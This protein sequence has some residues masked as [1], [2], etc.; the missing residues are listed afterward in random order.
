MVGT[1]DFRLGD[2]DKN[3]PPGKYV[4]Y[5][6]F[7]RALDFW[8]A[9]EKEVAERLSDFEAQGDVSNSVYLVLKGLDVFSLK[10]GPEARESDAVAE[11][12]DRHRG[13]AQARLIRFAVDQ[14]E[15]TG[16]LPKQSNARETLGMGWSKVMGGAEYNPWIVS[17]K[18]VGKNARFRVFDD[19]LGFWVAFEVE[20]RRRVALRVAQHQTDCTEFRNLQ[21]FD[22]HNIKWD[23]ESAQS[24]GI[25]AMF[26][27][28]RPNARAALVAFAVDRLA[29]TGEVP[30]QTNGKTTLGMMWTRATGT[31][32]YR[33][34]DPQTQTS[35]GK[36][37]MF[38]VFDSSQMMFE[39]ITHRVVMV[40]RDLVENQGADASDIRVAHL[41]R[42]LRK[43]RYSNLTE[44]LS[45]FQLTVCD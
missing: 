4:H 13:R 26:D 36:K 1:A 16:K 34:G 15:K 18:R 19:A 40:L 12:C 25:R 20:V 33:P 42:Y 21:T 28:Y 6:I 22:P 41:V 35:A 38:R 30:K 2:L 23:A 10:M 8:L 17:G 5:R 9:F 3:I 44:L 7:D 39:A 43:R 11:M 29:Q 31:G 37:A 27:R 14:F 32:I 45:Q 24:E